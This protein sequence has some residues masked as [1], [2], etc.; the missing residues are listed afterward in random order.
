MGVNTWLGAGA[1]APPPG[2]LG[3][4]HFTVVVPDRAELGRIEERLRALPGGAGGPAAGHPGA[5]EVTWA[6]DPSGNRVAIV[7]RA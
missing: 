3:L 6:E 2:S 7:T 5:P 4:H 1:P